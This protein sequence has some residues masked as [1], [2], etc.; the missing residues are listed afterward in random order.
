MSSYSVSNH[1]SD[2][3]NRTTTKRESDLSIASM[4]TDRI[5]RHEVLLLINHNHY[6]FRK[7]KHLGQTSQVGTMSKAKNFDI[8]QFPG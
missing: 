5:A 3:Q 6:N 8:S 7:K 1:T 4:I 2:K